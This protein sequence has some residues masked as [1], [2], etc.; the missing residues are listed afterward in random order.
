MGVL[1]VQ[2]V[3]IVFGYILYRIGRG[4]IFYLCFRK[5]NYTLLLMEMEFSFLIFFLFFISV[6]QENERLMQESLGRRFYR[7]GTEPTPLA[8]VEIP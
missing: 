8:K 3:H 7:N 1:V 6:R 4:K 5:F 2:N